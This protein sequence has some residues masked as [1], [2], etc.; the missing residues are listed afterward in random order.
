MGSPV[1]AKFN[2]DD[3]EY[4]KVHGIWWEMTLN[5]CPTSSPAA[6]V[7]RKFGVKPDPRKKKMGLLRF[8]H[9]LVFNIHSVVFHV[10]NVGGIW[11]GLRRRTIVR[12]VTRDTLC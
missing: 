3:D 12:N 4:I 1:G 9:D 11:R 6:P 5:T 8:S 10:E 7:F 2:D